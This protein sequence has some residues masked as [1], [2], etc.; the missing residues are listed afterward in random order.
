M[1]Q[2]LYEALTGKEPIFIDFVMDVKTRTR[3]HIHSFTVPAA[4]RC[5]QL[6]LREVKSA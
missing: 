5:V 1:A 4:C 2:M 6:R 3:D